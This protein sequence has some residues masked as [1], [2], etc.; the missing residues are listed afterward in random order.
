[1]GYFYYPHS[2]TALYNTQTHNA[3]VALPNI[4]CKSKI[5]GKNVNPRL[6]FYNSHTQQDHLSATTGTFDFSSHVTYWTLI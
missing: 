4:F 1:L 6:N 2:L 3:S 5:N